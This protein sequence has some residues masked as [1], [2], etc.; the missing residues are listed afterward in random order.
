MAAQ[1][2][3][4]FLAALAKAGAFGDKPN[5]TAGPDILEAPDLNLC[6]TIE[7]PP[8]NFN[9]SVQ[10]PQSKRLLALNGAGSKGKT[11]TVT[12]GQSISDAFANSQFVTWGPVTG[13]VEFG[14]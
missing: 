6:S 7:L 13:I 14:S 4:E 8:A 12:M 3:K 10:V 9:G 5:F 1:S 11:V 2:Y